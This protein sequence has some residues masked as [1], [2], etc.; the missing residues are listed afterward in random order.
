MSMPSNSYYKKLAERE[1]DGNAKVVN[2]HGFMGLYQMGKPALQDVGYID[3]HGNWTGIDGIRS[4]DDFLNNPA[5]QTKAIRAYHAIIWNN[6]LP[7]DVKESVGSRVNNI[8]LTKSGL[9]AGAHLVGHKRLTKFVREGVDC[10]DEIGTHCSEY[11][12]TFGE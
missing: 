7:T 8:K 1:S 12:K 6:Y 2:Q 9:I 10:T 4:R 3:E 5:V 11:V